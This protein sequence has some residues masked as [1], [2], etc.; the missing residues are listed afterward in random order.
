MTN[1]DGP[2][3][4]RGKW[5]QAGVPHRGWSCV[6]IEDLGEPSAICGMCETMEIRFVHYMQH[7][8][9]DEDLACGCIRAGNMEG[10]LVGADRRDKRMRSASRRRITWP[11]RSGWHESQ[12]GNLTIRANGFRVTVFSKNG[13]FSALVK[14][15][16]EDA[17]VWARRTYPTVRAA[18]LAAFDQMI[19]MEG[20][21]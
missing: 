14:D 20:K 18:Q 19:W 5:S 11:D 15:A 6:S 1:R 21:R 2:A 3:G 17:P 12:N 10:D 9:H 8:D 4:G 7:P 16:A 13:Q